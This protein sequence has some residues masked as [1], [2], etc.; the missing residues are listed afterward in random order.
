MADKSWKAFERRIAKAV[1]GQRRGAD[2]RNRER[3]GGKDDIVHDHLS[4]EVKLLKNVSYCNLLDAAKQAE[5]NAEDGKLPIAIIKKKNAR[6]ADA[7][8]VMR[9]ERFL[10]ATDGTED[11]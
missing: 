5:R 2:F 8:V 10:E 6:D 9:L 7:L 1:N 4:I 3:G 11:L